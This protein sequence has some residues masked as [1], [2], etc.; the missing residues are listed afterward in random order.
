MTGLQVNIMNPIDLVN[1]DEKH[2]RGRLH[3]TEDKRDA[4]NAHHTTRKREK[5]ALI[6]SRLETRLETRGYT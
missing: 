1:L 2:V 5:T 4:N 6:D 3:P